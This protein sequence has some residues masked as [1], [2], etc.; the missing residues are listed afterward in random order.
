MS[1]SSLNFEVLEKKIGYF[2]TDKKLLIQSL[3]HPSIN[4]N[5][6]KN[7]D[8]YKDNYERLEFLGDAVLNL[9]ISDA[10]I[11]LYSSEEEGNLAKKRSFLVCKETI[12]VIANRINLSDHIIMTEGAE[13]EG[14]RNN[15]SN[16]ENCFEAII[17]A[18]Y[19]DSNFPTASKFI[20]SLWQD[21]LKT[22]DQFIELVDPKGTLQEKAH[23]INISPIY[24]TLNVTGSAHDPI[25]EVEV[26]LNGFCI[27]AT[28][29][30]KK[31]AQKSAAKKMLES[32]KW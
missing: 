12:C 13:K 28:G 9:V 32:Y 26:C 17:G 19:L 11:K 18:V 3:S 23:K 30:S 7:R 22:A 20:L 14:G 4:H 21:L 15:F 27:N 25:F 2:F 1:E 5:L 24:N 16:I 10:L 31:E 8:N 6:S 29:N